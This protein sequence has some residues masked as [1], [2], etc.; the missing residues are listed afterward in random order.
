MPALLHLIG[1][2]L[3][4]R[5]EP[6]ALTRAVDLAGALADAAG[7]R[8]VAVGRSDDHLLVATWLADREALEPFAASAPHME[9]V[10]RGVAPVTARMW[11]AAVETEAPTESTI[12]GARTLWGFAMPARDG[13]YEWQVRQ[14]LAEV[15]A[16]PGSAAAGPTVE[17]RERFRAAGGV[18]INPDQL[19]FFEDALPAARARWAEIAGGLEEVLAPLLR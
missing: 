7:V 8:K 1:A 14:L 16:L 6:Q 13:V 12:A 4:E 19:P 15:E 5:A 11:S 2:S 18:L 9:F 10:M 17:E 3:R